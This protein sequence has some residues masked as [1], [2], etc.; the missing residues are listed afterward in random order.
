MNSIKKRLLIF[1]PSIESGGVEKNLFIISNYFIKNNI[2]V[3]I[4]TCNNNK[5]KKFNKNI[6]II[7]TKSNFWQNKSRK[8]KYIVCL[9]ILFFNL[10][11]NNKKT[12][13]LAFQANI[14]AILVCKIL[15][16]KIIVRSNS[17][18]SGWINN[19]ISKKFFSFIIKLANGVIVN[20]LDFKREFYRKFKI[21][22][23]CIYNPL[24]KNFL[25]L[26]KDK[27]KKKLFK[28]NS[29]NI[30]SVGRLTDQKDHI[31][32][33]KSIRFINEN[34]NPH[35]IIIGKGTNYNILK[36]FIKF[37]SLQNKVTLTG[38]IE[39]PIN[40][41]KQSDIL[42]L[43]SKFEGLPNILLEGQL[44]KKYII[45]TNCPTGPREILLN[46]KCGD[47]IK[48]GDYRN[49]AKL[50]NNFYKNKIL[51]QKKIKIASKNIK[52]FDYDENCKK[53]LNFV[54]ENF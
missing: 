8:I 41:I 44:L 11:F 49:L 5:K 14:Y 47:L 29:L 31:T 19:F 15:N 1:I 16:K 25:L 9:I 13:V 35:I 51:I 22:T 21:K 54:L 20:S 48:I 37:N 42:V 10:I 12:L 24:D 52:R 45:S 38:Y 3:E 40:Y 17:S 46:G 7:G 2:N 23:K 33:L 18:P 28:K 36:N 6:K 27:L 34:L 50:I 53:Y 26:K 39:N 4:L 30:L 43:T 32:L